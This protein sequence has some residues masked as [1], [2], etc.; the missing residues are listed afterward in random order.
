MGV[1][2]GMPGDVATLAAALSIPVYEMTAATGS[3]EDAFLH[4][5]T[6]EGR[7]G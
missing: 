6:A 2:G 4:L 3:L 1:P 7:P 5:T